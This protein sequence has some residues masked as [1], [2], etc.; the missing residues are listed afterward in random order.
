MPRKRPARRRRPKYIGRFRVP[1]ALV[2]LDRFGVIDKLQRFDPASIVQAVRRVF[3]RMVD[4]LC[5]FAAV[6]KPWLLHMLRTFCAFVRSGLEAICARMK[7][8]TSPPSRPAPSRQAPSRQAPS[9]QTSGIGAFEIHQRTQPPHRRGASP[10]VRNLPI[11]AL[12]GVALLSTVMIAGITVRSVRTK[13][14]NHELAARRAQLVSAASETEAPSL[15]PSSDPS[16]VIAPPETAAPTAAPTP[17]PEAAAQPL[18]VPEATPAPTPRVFHTVGGTPLA[19]MEALHKENHDLIGWL[20]IPEVLDLPVVYKDN[21]YYLKRDFH[22]QK[23][24]AGTIF[25]DVHHRFAAQTQNLLLHGHNMKDGTMF[26][27]LTQYLSGVDYVIHHPFIQFDTL[28]KEEQYVI[29]AVLRVSLD[30]N[31]ER[32]FNYFSYPTFPSDQAFEHFVRQAQ[33]RSEYAIPLS[34]KPDDAL[35]TLSTCLDEDRL[36]IL[37]RRLRE[38]ETRS[39]LRASIRLSTEQ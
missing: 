14:L 15:D 16:P 35:L 34:V 33:L 23:N 19:H 32:F 21:S 18:D 1:D 28:W 6:L 37:A 7:K 25:L 29:F 2:E 10:L 22:K 26:G 39:Q 38:G 30:V 12:C 8:R 11:I 9:R 24:N 3:L 5:V 31:D 17:A 13:R 27:R 36:V 20:S 4:G